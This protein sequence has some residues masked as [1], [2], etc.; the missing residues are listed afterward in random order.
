[1]S[2]T[3]FHDCIFRYAHLFRMLLRFLDPCSLPAPL[4][5][6]ASLF[7][8]HHPLHPLHPL[9][10]PFP[11]PVPPHHPH[12]LLPLSPYHTSTLLTLPQLLLPL[13]LLLLL[14]LLLLSHSCTALPPL[15]S[16]MFPPPYTPIHTGHMEG[17]IMRGHCNDE[18]WGLATHPTQPLYCTTG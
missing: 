18:L 1:M 2:L 5:S 10:S 15:P 6:H 4:S 17:V 13:F 16:P 14:L 7:S 3:L 8:S 12:S 11:F 9:P